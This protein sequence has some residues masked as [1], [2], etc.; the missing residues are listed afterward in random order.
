MAHKILCWMFLSHRSCVIE[1][2][3][4]SVK[5]GTKGKQRKQRWNKFYSSAAIAQ[6][7]LNEFD[8]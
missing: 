6:I 8:Y 3:I 4:T 2:L 1:N 7:K 5:R